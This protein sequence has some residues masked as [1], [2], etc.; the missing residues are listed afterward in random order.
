MELEL[1]KKKIHTIRGMQV[2]FDRDLAE[3]YQVETR[4]LNQAV[5]RNIDRFPERYMFQINKIEFKELRSNFINE[6]ISQNVT[7]NKIKMG[8][9]KLPYAFT[10]H[11]I[12]MLS[13]VLKSKKAIMINILIIDA[14]IAMRKFLSTN[15]QFIQ[16]FQQIDQKLLEHD[17]NFDKIFDLMQNNI[18]KQGIFFDGQIFDSYK[19]VCDLIKSAKKSII[20]IDNYIDET[21]LEIFTKT[22]INVKIYTANYLKLDVDK[23]LKQYNNV[24]IIKF[25]KSHDRF[26]IIDDMVYHIG[27]S[28]K[29]LGK[30]WFAFSKL[31][32][33]GLKLLDQI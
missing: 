21:V 19:F 33:D 18:P 8:L 32:K 20:L 30:K 14:F 26:L 9:R 16:K 12:T 31:D 29:D 15:N 25:S 4:K 5:K 7:S 10:E 2:I 17:N 22:K 23:Y 24:E 27:A 1:I 11:G 28:L 3:L 6:W 13:S